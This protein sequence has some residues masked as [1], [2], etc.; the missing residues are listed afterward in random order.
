MI[1]DAT[2]QV[3]LDDHHFILKENMM[4]VVTPVEIKTRG[5]AEPTESNMVLNVHRLLL[6]SWVVPL[7]EY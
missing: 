4:P 3:V 2:C 5:L 6:G 7:Q 1:Q